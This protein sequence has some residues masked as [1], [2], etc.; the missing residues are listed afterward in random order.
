MIYRGTDLRAFSPAAVDRARVARLRESWGVAPHERVVLIAARLTAWKGQKVLIEA[1]SR[2]KAK[3]VDGRA[4]HPR[5]R[6][7]GARQLRQG[8]STR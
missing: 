1:A 7:A 2:L 8:D 3:G 5:G 4:L 6:S